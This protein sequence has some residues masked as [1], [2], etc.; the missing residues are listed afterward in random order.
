MVWARRPEA[1][2]ALAGGG[3]HGLGVGGAIEQRERHRR[4]PWARG[5][6]LRC[7]ACGRPLEVGQSAEID[8]DGGAA[9]GGLGT[10]GDAQVLDGLSGLGQIFVEA[11]AVGARRHFSSS[12]RPTG[13]N[14]VAAQQLP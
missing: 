9:R 1:R 11:S 13:L 5:W 2:E 4:S 12:R 14:N 7:A 10:R 8:A 6:R 3:E